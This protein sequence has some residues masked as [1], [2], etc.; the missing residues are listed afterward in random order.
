MKNPNKDVRIPIRYEAYSLKATKVVILEST[1]ERIRSQVQDLDRTFR[2]F[3]HAQETLNRL[4][5]DLDDALKTLS[6]VARDY[7]KKNT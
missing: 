5:G 4:S 3:N 7:E 1:L 2:Y 6:E